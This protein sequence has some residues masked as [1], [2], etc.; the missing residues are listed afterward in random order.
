M[1][2]DTPI[3]KFTSRIL[4]R[5]VVQSYSTLCSPMDCRPLGSSVHGIFQARIPEWVTI[6]W[7]S[8]I[9]QLVKNLC[10]AGDPSSIPGSGKSPGEGIGYPL[11]YSWASVVVQLVKNPPIEQ[12][13][14]IR[15][16][17]REDPLE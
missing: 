4:L 6:S 9:A 3:F 17:S 7:A 1:I 10:N 2:Y 5:L 16:L 8:L 15:S 12:E 13:M 14:Q 11:Q